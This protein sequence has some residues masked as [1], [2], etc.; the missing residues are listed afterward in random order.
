ML[1]DSF[2]IRIMQ[3]IMNDTEMKTIDQ[4]RLFIQVS[5]GLELKPVSQEEKY[6]WVESVVMRFRYDR[7]TRKDKGIIRKNCSCQDYS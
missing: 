3:M 5:Q 1:S 6:R 4:V 2:K 7:L